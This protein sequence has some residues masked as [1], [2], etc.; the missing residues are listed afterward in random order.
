MK[1]KLVLLGLIALGL[2]AGCSRQPDTSAYN[3]AYDGLSDRTIPPVDLSIL[4]DQSQAGGQQSGGDTG[5]P[6]Q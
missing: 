2:L 5:V 4:Q 3:P 1:S 6:G